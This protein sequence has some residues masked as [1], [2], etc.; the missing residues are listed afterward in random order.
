MKIWI[1]SDLH[2][3]YAGLKEPLKPPDADVCVMAGDLCWIIDI[4]VHWLARH[5][6]PAMPC[7]YVAGNHEFYKGA[8][9]EGIEAGRAAARSRTWGRPFSSQTAWS[10]V[11]LPPLVM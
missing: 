1:L 5:I 11:F 2:L 4:G 3:E 10:L 7:I 6:A 9:V 8:I